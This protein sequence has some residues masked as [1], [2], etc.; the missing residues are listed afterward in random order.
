MSSGR[1]R[2]PSMRYTV[3]PLARHRM[4][5]HRKDVE[6]AQEIL[7]AQPDPREMAGS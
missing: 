5:V 2:S 7:G 1:I 3:G 6:R 4:F